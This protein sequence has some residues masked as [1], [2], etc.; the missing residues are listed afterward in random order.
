MIVP[1]HLQDAA[2]SMIGVGLLISPWVGGYGGDR[3][4]TGNAVASGAFIALVALAA[5]FFARPWQAWVQAGSGLWVIAS[6]WMLGFE[7]H[8][9]AMATAVGIGIPVFLLAVWVLLDMVED[10]A[11]STAASRVRGARP[12][13]RKATG[14]AHSPRR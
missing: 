11:A 14:A 6:P 4:A 5:T 12:A 1:R 8:E 9:I 2:S 7:A 13:R 3:L 10:G